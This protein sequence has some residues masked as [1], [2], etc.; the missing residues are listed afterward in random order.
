MNS[1]TETPAPSPPPAKV[2]RPAVGD[3]VHYYDETRIGS[4]Q[5]ALAARSIGVG[6]YAAIVVAHD[7]S[8]LMLDVRAPHGGFFAERV[9]HKRELPRDN[10][11]QL[12]P[13]KKRWWQHSGK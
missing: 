1:K 10:D 8:G 3:I 6:P 4:F 9:P 12:L 13:G 7:L 11:G 2:A 5:G